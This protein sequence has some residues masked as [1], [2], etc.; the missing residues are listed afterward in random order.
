MLEEKPTEELC[1]NFLD[2]II[3]TVC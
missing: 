1:E 2:V 3:R